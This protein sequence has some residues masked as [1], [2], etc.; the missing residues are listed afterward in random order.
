MKAYPQLGYLHKAYNDLIVQRQNTVQDSI[1]THNDRASF[2]FYIQRDIHAYKLQSPEQDNRRC[3]ALQD[4][5]YC[6][7]QQVIQS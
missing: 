6:E 2:N 3:E 7:H 4:P 1:H 5:G